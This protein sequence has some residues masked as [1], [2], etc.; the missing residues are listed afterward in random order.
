MTSSDEDLQLDLAQAK[1]ATKNG[2]ISGFSGTGNVCTGVFQLRM[3]L[4][5]CHGSG[6]VVFMLL[7]KVGCF[8]GLFCG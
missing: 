3:V 8:S 6:T 2:S 7:A 1:E 5:Q 4:Q